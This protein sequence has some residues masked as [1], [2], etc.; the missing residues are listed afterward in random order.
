MLAQ[1]E[2][3]GRL[4]LSPPALAT[5]KGAGGLLRPVTKRRNRL[6]SSEVNWV[7]TARRCFTDS[8][9]SV[10]SSPYLP[11]EDNSSVNPHHYRDTCG[12]PVI[13]RLCFFVVFFFSS[14]TKWTNC[15]IV[16]S[17]HWALNTMTTN[18]DPM[19]VKVFTR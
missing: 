15:A 17:G 1:V 11:K 18:C 10:K 19:R 3:W 4:S 6:R 2:A 7:R 13:K 5:V 9:D 12:S 14:S 16:L 8:E